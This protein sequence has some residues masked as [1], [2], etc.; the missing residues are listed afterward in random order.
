MQVHFRNA[1]IIL[2]VW[3]PSKINVACWVSETSTWSPDPDAP[4][5]ARYNPW[6]MIQTMN[7]AAHLQHPPC[8]LQPGPYISFTL[9][10]GRGQIFYFSASLFIYR[11]TRAV[12]FFFTAAARHF[13]SQL[14]G[15]LA[16]PCN[17]SQPLAMCHTVE[18]RWGTCHDSDTSA[19]KGR[20]CKCNHS[21]TQCKLPA[22][23]ILLQ[24]N[25]N[26]PSWMDETNVLIHFNTQ[27]NLEIASIKAFK[28]IARTRTIENKRAC[29]HL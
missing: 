4:S 21:P 16:S 8:D 17:Q 14:L 15:S 29:A 28:Q 3:K 12:F 25:N 23:E 9:W 26:T 6:A 11:E 7:T 10:I 1:V 20:L 18:R 24:V 22:C 19:L 2:L 5:P 13:S 27:S